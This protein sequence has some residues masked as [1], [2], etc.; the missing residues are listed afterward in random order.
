MYFIIFVVLWYVATWAGKHS[1]NLANG[2]NYNQQYFL[3][4]IWG[5]LVHTIKGL[6]M[7]YSIWFFYYC[8]V[9]YPYDLF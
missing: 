4:G 1:V 8:F 3:Q 7:G 2:M 5:I 6:T 9:N